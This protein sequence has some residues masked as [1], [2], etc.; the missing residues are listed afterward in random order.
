MS[1]YVLKKAAKGD[2]D[3]GLKTSEY[4]SQARGGQHR[5]SPI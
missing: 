5:R 1:E 3:D 2:V 4:Y